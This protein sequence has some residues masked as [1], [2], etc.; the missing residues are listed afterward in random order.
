MGTTPDDN[1]RAM[2]DQLIAEISASEYRSVRKVAAALNRDYTTVYR[3]VTNKQPIRMDVLFDILAL[4]EIEP[5]VFFTRA[6]ERAETAHP[7]D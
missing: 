5:G 3:W 4:L 1:A 6:Q 7:T 2:S